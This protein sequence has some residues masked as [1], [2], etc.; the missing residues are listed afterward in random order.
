MHTMDVATSHFCWAHMLDAILYLCGIA[1]VDGASISADA[2]YAEGST[3]T[4]GRWRLQGNANAT[5]A[6]SLFRMECRGDWGAFTV[7]DVANHWTAIGEAVR[8]MSAG[9]SG[10]CDHDRRGALAKS[11]SRSFETFLE[12]VRGTTPKASRFADAVQE[13]RIDAD[14]AAMAAVR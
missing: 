10:T 13:L 7:S 1:S 6:E 11:I 9:A 8:I 12:L 5:L 2:R 14:I 3:E 4:G